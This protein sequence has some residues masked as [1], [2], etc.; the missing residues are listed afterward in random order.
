[1]KHSHY[2]NWKLSD[3]LKRSREEL[4]GY[5]EWNDSNG[6]WSDKDTEEEGIPKTS[7]LSARDE[8]FHSLVV[9]S[10]MPKLGGVVSFDQVVSALVRAAAEEIN[11]D[12]KKDIVD[13]EVKTFAELNDYVDANMYGGSIF[14]WNLY[15]LANDEGDLS[16]AMSLAHTILDIWIKDGRPHSF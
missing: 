10:A 13:K 14:L 15:G 11:L 8:V 4:L 12:I 16:D 9:N 3:V 5:L 2:Q 1:M 7:I 6:I